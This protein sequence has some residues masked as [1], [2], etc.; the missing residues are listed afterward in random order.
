MDKSSFTTICKNKYMISIIIQIK[1]YNIRDIKIL[2][3]FR[4]V[5]SWI[6]LNCN[7]N[8]ITYLSNWITFKYQKFK[9][10]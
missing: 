6:T 7:F 3:V 2:P 10:I 8:I 9:L 4:P 5:G 1:N